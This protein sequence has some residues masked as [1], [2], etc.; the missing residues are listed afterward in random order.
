MTRNPMLAERE[1]MVVSMR[2][3]RLAL[4]D[5]DLLADVDSAVA[6]LDHAARITWEY[7]TEVRRSDPL[8]A[9][10]GPALGLTSAQVDDLF[11]AA[12]RL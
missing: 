6:N 4:L 9:Q 5:A 7:A 2:Q 8:V 1:R 3:A 11:R 10:L 12:A